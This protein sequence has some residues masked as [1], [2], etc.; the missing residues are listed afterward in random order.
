MG[1]LEDDGRPIPTERT[2]A[3]EP[4]LSSFARQAFSL[5]WMRRTLMG[6][7]IRPIAASAMTTTPVALSCGKSQAQQA[8]GA[9]QQHPSTGEFPA[10]VSRLERAELEEIYR[11][12]RFH[13]KG[14]MI[15]RGIHRQRCLKQANKLQDYADQV[16]RI[17]TERSSEKAQSYAVLEQITALVQALEADGDDLAE[18]YQDFRYGGH[19]YGGAPRIGKLIQS[20]ITFINNWQR[21]KQAFRQ[22]MA[23]QPLPAALAPAGESLG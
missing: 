20:V 5:A 2:Q 12:L 4:A 6:S 10:D 23:A 7:L 13:Y 3:S 11:K 9:T 17:A 22:L 16:R 15:S 21:H 8:V 18:S 19:P 14:V 1:V